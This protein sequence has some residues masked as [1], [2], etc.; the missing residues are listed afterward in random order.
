MITTWAPWLSVPELV[1]LYMVNLF[2]LGSPRTILFGMGQK[3]HSLVLGTFRWA[4]P[5]RCGARHGFRS[6]LSVQRCP[7]SV[8]KAARAR[9]WAGAELKSAMA[10]SALAMRVTTCC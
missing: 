5:R 1:S 10:C 2:F 4:D 8:A 9:S 7:A 3:R 6:C